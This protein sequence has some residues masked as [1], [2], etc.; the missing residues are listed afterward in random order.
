MR[1]QQWMTARPATAATLLASVCLIAPSRSADAQLSPQ[2]IARAAMPTVAQIVT[3]DGDGKR[4]KLGSGFLV[5]SSRYL[6]TNA[7]VL[8]GASRVEVVFARSQAFR[9]VKVLVYDP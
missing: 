6:V 2:A 1:P 4:S 8:R 7:H 5:N 9:Q 3:Y